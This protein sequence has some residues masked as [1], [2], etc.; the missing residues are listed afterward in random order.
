MSTQVYSLTLNGL[1]GPQ[2][3]SN[4]LHYQFDDAGF[5]TRALAAAALIDAWDTAN[6]ATFRTMI[7]TSCSIRSLKSRCVSAPGG[8]EAFKGLTGVTAGSRGGN[9]TASGVAP[10]ITKF[11]ANFAGQIGK[12]FLPGVTDSDMIDGIWQ[13]GF[14]TAV[15]AGKHIFTDTLVL[16]GGGGPTATPVV[17]NRLLHVARPIIAAQLQAYPGTQRRRQLPV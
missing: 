17:W 4:V 11:V 1:V 5:S 6:R 10:F 13:S 12:T 16:T 7:P 2:F 9:L 15:A 8:F 14:I 3:Y